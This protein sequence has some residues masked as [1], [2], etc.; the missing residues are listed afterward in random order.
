MRTKE[1]GDRQDDAGMAAP[2]ADKSPGTCTF[3]YVP[4]LCLFGPY[5]HSMVSVL[6]ASCLRF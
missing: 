4:L 6:P 2:C 1:S 3:P 5:G